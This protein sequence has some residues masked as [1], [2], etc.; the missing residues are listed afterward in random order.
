MRLFRS[1]RA[2]VVC[3]GISSVACF[4]VGLSASFLLSTPVGASVVVTDLALFLLSCAVSIL[5]RRH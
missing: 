1:F 2:V 5:R 3:A 4:F